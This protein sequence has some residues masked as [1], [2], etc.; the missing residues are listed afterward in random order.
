MCTVR[1]SD[2]LSCMHASPLATHALLAMHAPL[3]RMPLP[4]H[5]C[6]PP[7]TEVLIYLVEFITGH[8]EVVAKVIFLHLSVILLTGGGV[9]LSAYW[10]ATPPPPEQTC[11]P[12]ADTP[13]RAD[14]PQEQTSPPG[15]DTPWHRHAP[16]G[17][18][19]PPPWSRHTPCCQTPPG[20]DTPLPQD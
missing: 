8:N 13:P 1:F 7:R 10:D 19:P 18:T 12:G 5:A 14:T 9:C 16:L 15:A 17:Q 20:A 11:L 3:P 2:R 4:C 6:P